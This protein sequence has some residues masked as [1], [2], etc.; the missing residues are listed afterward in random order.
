MALIH[1][2]TLVDADCS[3]AAGASMSE[4]SQ[5]NFDSRVRLES[6][7]CVTVLTWTWVLTFP[8]PPP[9]L[10]SRSLIL[11]LYERLQDL[12]FTH[13]LTATGTATPRS[14]E[15]PGLAMQNQYIE[16]AHQIKGT[17]CWKSAH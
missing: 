8:A 11:P 14:P 17:S 7:E 10:S 6:T 1:C 2:E 13:T 12:V 4:G 15:P 16:P 9:L 5:Q 3:P